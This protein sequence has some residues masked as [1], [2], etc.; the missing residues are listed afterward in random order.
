MKG[1]MMFLL[2][3]AAGRWCAAAQFLPEKTFDVR[4]TLWNAEAQRYRS[5]MRVQQPLRSL[6]AFDVTYYKLNLTITT[7]PNYLRGIVTVKAR[8]TT[9]SLDSITL[10]L[11]NAM[12]VD[13]VTMEG[14]SVHFVQHP[15][16]VSI[17]L[18]RS[19]G[20]G[21]MVVLDVYYRGVPASS[22]F[23]SFEFGSHA[24]T[25]WVW[26]L[27]EPY[28]AR[29]WWPCKDH[30]GDKADSVDIWVTCSRSYKVASNGKLVAIVENPDL[31]HTYRWA[32]RYPI[33]TYLV[34]IALTDY[35]E[36]AQWFRYSPTDSMQV[37]NYVLPEHLALHR[38]STKDVVDMLRIFSDRFG[39]YPFI[40]EKYGHAE[41]GRGGAMEHQTMTSAVY[42]AFT[43]YVLA[44]ELAHQWFGD[45]ITCASWQDLWLNEGFASYGESIY[46]EGKYGVDAYRRSMQQ[47]MSIARTGVGPAFKRDTANIG[48]LFDQKT[49]YRRGASTLHMLRHVLGDSL[50][51]RCVR[52]YVADPRFRFGVATTAGF[53]NVCE[54]VSGR[55]L[56]WFFDE[57]IFG[58]KY[59]RY[60]FRWTVEEGGRE[61]YLVTI[62]LRQTTGTTNPP[63]FTMPIDFKLT[64][65]GWD[66]T[67]VLFNDANPQQFIVSC[68]HQPTDITLDPDEW[69]LRYVDDEELPTSYRLHQNYPNPF[70]AGTT[71]TVSLPNAKHATL[72]I[73]D[74]L[75][76]EVATLIDEKLAP[77][78]HAL[79]FD[80][81][82]LASGVYYARLHVEGFSQTI[83]MA[84]I[85]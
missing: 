33:A 46:A 31:T 73:F 74:L 54:A 83:K 23:G 9:V 63:F 27:S 62:T 85:R 55:S 65:P 80:G 64:A 17:E 21:E 45:L 30:P 39:L 52:S 12:V 59:P 34:S 22:G 53:R 50:F 78:K 24:G 6:G 56:G 81:T 66:T 1:L 71:I 79:S 84:L 40:N 47:T 41:F 51:F 77:G 82:N 19:Y 4:E 38:D 49:T 70:N 75:G 36:F 20:D 7:S 32:E 67:V 10:D 5:L 8:S 48:T 28:G 44:H 69:I 57:W 68:S 18:N 43:T 26:S 3:G 60:S 11:T 58:E 72:K 15:T 14:T 13:S 42:A 37:L 76:R 61:G 2:I 35:A 25:P 29:D 16:T